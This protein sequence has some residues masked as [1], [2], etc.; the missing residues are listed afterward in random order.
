[1]TNESSFLEVVIRLFI[2]YQVLKNTKYNILRSIVI[3]NISWRMHSFD[4]F[5]SNIEIYTIF[6]SEKYFKIQQYCI[7]SHT[8]GISY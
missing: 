5:I 1:M 3:K 6:E 8:E 2:I 4:K 7:G